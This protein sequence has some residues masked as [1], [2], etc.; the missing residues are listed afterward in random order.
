MRMPNKAA[1]HVQLP[2]VLI[3]AVG[4]PD[5]LISPVTGGP[6]TCT[7]LATVNEMV[8]TPL[9]FNLKPWAG[10][11]T[12]VQSPLQA[13][14]VTTMLVAAFGY[15]GAF[16]VSVPAWPTTRGH[17]LKVQVTPLL[18]LV[19]INVAVLVPPLVGVGLLPAGCVAVAVGPGGGV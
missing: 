3:K 9:P 10:E 13:P 18:L 1:V 6:P 8:S 19:Q 14:K 16:M 4:P 11:S 5:R 7:S 15:P 2:C 17:G 12:T